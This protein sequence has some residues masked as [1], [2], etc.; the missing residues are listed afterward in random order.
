MRGNVWYKKAR[1]SVKMKNFM[2]RDKT[3]LS[4][5]Y[6]FTELSKVKENIYVLFQKFC[7]TNVYSFSVVRQGLQILIFNRSNLSSKSTLDYYWKQWNECLFGS[8][9]LN[10]NQNEARRMGGMPMIDVEAEA[11]ILGPPDAK[12][13]LMW[14]DPDAG[15]D[16]ARRRRGQQKMR[17]LDGIT[18]SM[19]MGLG[20]LQEFLMDR[21]AWRAVVHG[22]TKSQT[23]PSDWLNLS[24]PYQVNKMWGW[25]GI[26]GKYILCLK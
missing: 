3:S 13:W 21:E 8:N 25:G 2:G 24:W 4:K 15:K 19:E 10:W 26:K 16:R 18:D 17:W 9:E 23:Q 14:K 20:G 6:K 5:Q 11:P 22:V 1:K 7:S 12:S